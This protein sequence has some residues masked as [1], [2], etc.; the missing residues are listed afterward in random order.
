MK[1]ELL[2]ADEAPPP[3]PVD[4]MERKTEEEKNED[5]F[6]GTDFLCVADVIQVNCHLLPVLYIC[7]SSSASCVC[8]NW[9]QCVRELQSHSS[10]CW[11]QTESHLL[12]QSAQR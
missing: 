11:T 5:V 1:A 8:I 7:S 2:E 3:P 9:R 6:P 12:I 10:T 4:I